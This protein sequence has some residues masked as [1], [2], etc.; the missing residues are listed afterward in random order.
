MSKN[1]I[2]L[3]VLFY[4]RVCFTTGMRKVAMCPRHT[5]KPKK[6]LAK[7]LSSVTL[8][9]Q[10]SAYTES[11]NVSLPSVF[12]RALGKDFAECFLGTDTRQ[13]N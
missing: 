9:K 4:V 13:K 12:Y 5:A 7:P 1:H 6:H 8:G 3:V 10:H 2:F 11:A